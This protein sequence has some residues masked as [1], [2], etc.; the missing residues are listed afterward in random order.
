MKHAT[1]VSPAPHTAPRPRDVAELTEAAGY[2]SISVLMPTQ[3]GRR[4]AT[5]DVEQ[6]QELV[7]EVQRRLRADGVPAAD[8]L[9]ARLAE[10]VDLVV[11]Q[12][13]DR[14]L[15]IY[16]SLDV[17]RT[18]RLTTRV[19]P[20]AVVEQTFATRDLVQAL[21]RRPPHVVLVV[22]AGC[23]HLYQASS[24]A[25]R[26]VGHRDLF[27][28]TVALPLPSAELPADD[29][30]D[31]VDDDELVRG[32]LAEIDAMLGAYRREHPSPLVLA[33]SP[34]MLDRFC[35]LSRNLQRLAGR[36]APQEAQTPAALA[37]ATASLLED[38]LRSRRQE[39]REILGEA[40]SRRPGDVARGVAEA[41]QAVHSRRPA[42]LLVE[43]DFVS[44]GET[45][46]V[47]DLVDDLIEVVILRG[48]QLALVSPGELAEH[49]HLALVSRPSNRS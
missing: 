46:R 10:L 33:G 24:G 18:F 28:R 49:G 9:M 44:E 20:R 29:P 25:M 36:V 48:G 2:P 39:A 30:L 35:A 13:A 4:M 15:A 37:R 11:H 23:A 7:R 14:A 26:L 5:A 17:A 45:P 41:W 1:L 42:L 32:F 12:P 22:E 19:L 3:P 16:V 47:H 27:A 8:R 38:Y 40:L 34:G 21:H 6:L 31:T 43:E